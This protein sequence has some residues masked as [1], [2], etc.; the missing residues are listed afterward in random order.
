[1]VSLPTATLQPSKARVSA[2]NL[3]PSLVFA[4]CW[5]VL[6]ALASSAA[7]LRTICLSL[8]C[9]VCLRVQAPQ[10]RPCVVRQARQRRLTTRSRRTASPPLNSSV[11]PMRLLLTAVLLLFMGV[12]HGQEPS[13][14]ASIAG[15]WQFGEHTVWIRIDP[16]GTAYQ[17]RIAPGGTVYTSEGTFAPPSSIRWRQIWGTDQISNPQAG[18]L[19]LK[20][21]YGSFEYHATSRPMYG[22]CAAPGQASNSSSKRTRVPRA[23]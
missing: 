6:S 12:A 22:A 9:N 17:C 21:P 10:R 2:P 15:L 7:S 19:I 23:A 11:K 18:T 8:R 1:V 4:F 20:G 3:P 16:N 5:P 14:P 13:V